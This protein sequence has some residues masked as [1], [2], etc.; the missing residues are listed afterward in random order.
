[1]SLFNKKPTID[2]I[3][4]HLQSKGIATNK[5][6]DTFVDFKLYDLNWRL[7][8]EKDGLVISVGLG[9]NPEFNRA[10][11]AA[12]NNRINNE[13][14]LVKAYVDSYQPLDKE[15][16]PIPEAETE[17]GLVFHLETFCY[18]Q[19][20]FRKAYEFGIF[21]I[22]DAMEFHNRYYHQL[23]EEERT[24]ATNKIGFN[25]HK[26]ENAEEAIVAS[27]RPRPIGFK[28]NH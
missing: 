26:E 15:G 17:Y 16:K 23:G 27:D 6:S 14:F 1:M 11:M 7:S 2:S 22:K 25:A 21:A 18:T 9:I 28:T 3:I 24:Q 12:A 20:D 10:C 5:L 19:D 4:N 8:Y 13:R